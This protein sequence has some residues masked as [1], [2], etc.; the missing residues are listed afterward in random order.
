METHTLIEID[1]GSLADYLR[2]LDEPVLEITLLKDW[3]GFSPGDDL[4]C[5]H[6]SLYHALYTIKYAS[7]TEYLHTDPMRIRLLARPDPGQCHHY[8]AE[9]G[10]FCD[11]AAEKRNYCLRHLHLH[12]D[13]RDL[14]LFD[15]LRDF[16][17]NA[18]NIRWS[19]RDLLD[20]LMKGLVTVS[21][22]PEKVDRAM[23]IMELTHVNRSILTR[24]YRL[25]ARRSHPDYL[26]GDDE[27]MKEINWAY[28]VLKEV[29]PL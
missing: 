23:R 17:C 16:Y 8:L 5:H 22:D 29:Y 28:E 7:L 20:R 15:P 2:S 3:T 19:E 13:A 14:P 21:L 9:E 26:D 10:R 11:S 4:Y 1:T 6:F 18:E 24:K 12:V 25:L 27:R